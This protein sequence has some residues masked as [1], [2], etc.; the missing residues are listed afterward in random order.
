MESKKSIQSVNRA[1]EILSLFNRRRPRLGITEISRILGLPKGTVHGIVRTLLKGR[2]LQQELE[3]RKYQ[4]GLKIYEMGVTLVGNL[5]INQRAAGPLNKL[6]KSSRL[7]SRMAIWDGDSA[8]I[9][10]T[11]DPHFNAPFFNQIGPHVPGYSSAVGKAILASLD[12]QELNSY[13]DQTDLV[14][15]TTKTITQRGRL[16]RD[17]EKTRQKGYATDQEESVLGMSCIGAP[18]Y[19]REGNLVASISLSGDPQHFQGKWLEG[20][21]EKLL[22]VAGEISRAMGYFPKPLDVRLI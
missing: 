21:S 12:E 9:I 8:L 10:L 1:I 14:P 15:Y 13:L 16:L 2:F 5:E 19:G 18:I 3:G 22:K 6:S 4:L 20:M 17:L 11:I 7:V